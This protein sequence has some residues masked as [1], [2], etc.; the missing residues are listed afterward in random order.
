MNPTDLCASLRENLPVLFECSVAPQGSVRVRTP[1]LYPDGDLVDVFVE[2]RGSQYLVTDY[3]EALGWLQVQSPSARLTPKQRRMAED[4]CLTLRVDLDR[5]QLVLRNVETSALGEAVHNVGQAVV[6]VS[7]IW[8][9]VQTRTVETIGDQVD[10]W[11]RERNFD[12]DKNQ[13]RSG[14]SGRVWTVDYEVSVADKTS[15]VFV[16]STGT[17]AWARRLS[18]RVVAACTDLG[19]VPRHQPNT[20]F[21]SLFDDTANVW[22]DEDFALV[23]HHSRVATWSRPDEFESI[24]T[25]DWVSPPPLFDRQ[26]GGQVSSA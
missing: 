14:H 24:L 4:V 13:Q 8:F 9:T 19:D 10:E 2:E 12:F 20:G 25:T 23:G 11:L 21:V 22:R 7:D 17:P 16:L 18:E 26:S 15:L 6:R 3:G 1:F 5:G